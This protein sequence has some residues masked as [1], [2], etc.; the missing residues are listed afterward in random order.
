MDSAL[1]FLVENFKNLD[2]S[3]G[4][5]IDHSVGVFNI[6]KSMKANND[7]C[8]AGLYHSIYGTD[9]FKQSVTVTRSQVEELIGKYA[10]Q[11]VY[12]FCNTANKDS[13]FLKSP[14]TQQDEDLLLIAYANLKEQQ[15]R[16]NNEGLD[17]LV[18]AYENIIFNIPEANVSDTVISPLLTKT[19]NKIVK[20]N[21]NNKDLIVLDNVFESYEMD[22]LNSVC[23]NSMYRGDH[24]ASPLTTNLDFRFVSYLN[25]TQV[26]DTGLINLLSKI[27]KN[28]NE[29]FYGGHFYINHY[30]HYTQSPKHT[31]S[32]LD[33]TYTI[34]IFCNNHWSED[35][36]GEIKFYSH[37]SPDNI[38]IDFIPGR[39]LIFDSRLEHKVLPLS[40][41]AKKPRFSLAVK[42]SNQ[43]GLTSLI[44]MYGE[45]NILLLENKL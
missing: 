24:G 44:R 36:G 15:S 20:L 7:I 32:S 23:I 14:T 25:K 22:L 11:L 4:N 28:T 26:V 5:Y 35:W 41:E 10:E 6:L 12:T 17:M 38:T 27:S 8:L 13:E 42:A 34:L 37:N 19:D 18:S 16:A 29:Q 2:H 30:W 43:H 1:N 31:D 39:V 21:I 45:E 40:L 9:A 3:N 33:G